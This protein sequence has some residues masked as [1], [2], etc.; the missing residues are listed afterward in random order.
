[1]STFNYEPFNDSGKEIRIVALQPSLSFD[2]SIECKLFCVNLARSQQYEALS[3]RWGD[4]NLTQCILLNGQDFIVT[5]NLWLALLH[6]R[7]K[8]EP[9]DIWVDALCI[10]QQNV[11]E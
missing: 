2:T 4:D 9:R 8:T 1:M 5:Q 6:L 10:D 11:E 7:H 3:Y